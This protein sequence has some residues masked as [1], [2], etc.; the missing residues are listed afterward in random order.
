[1]FLSWWSMIGLYEFIKPIHHEH[2]TT[3]ITPEFA[4]FWYFFHSHI[5]I[6]LLVFV[7]P[8]SR[9]D[10]FYLFIWIISPLLPQV[11]FNIYGDILWKSYRW[12]RD[13]V[14]IVLDCNIEVSFIWG[15]FVITFSDF[16]LKE[17]ENRCQPI[18][19][20]WENVIRGPV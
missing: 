15:Y 11:F 12:G 19:L 2:Y 4:I 9:L 14:A 6:Y 17:F 16:F 5:R 3:Q 7:N 13:A 20:W 10:S 18:P 1:M 8:E